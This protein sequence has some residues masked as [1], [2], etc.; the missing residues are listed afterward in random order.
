M[1]CA[2]DAEQAPLVALTVELGCFPLIV[3]GTV[4]G[5]PVWYRARGG[6]WEL[7]EWLPEDADADQLWSVVAS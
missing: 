7:Y 6:R 3:A 5:R 1:T 2:A 4:A